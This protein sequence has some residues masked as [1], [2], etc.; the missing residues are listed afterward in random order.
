M[1]RSK[2]QPVTIG[3]LVESPQYFEETMRTF[4]ERGG[5]PA[6]QRWFIS[7]PG[8]EQAIATIMLDRFAE[9]LLGVM[10]K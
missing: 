1:P 10:P 9:A 8:K 5:M 6:L 2:E 7:N 4:F 3:D